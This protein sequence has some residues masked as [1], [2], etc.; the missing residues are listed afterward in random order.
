M[1]NHLDIWPDLEWLSATTRYDDG[2]ITLIAPN[3]EFRA[4]RGPLAQ[5]SQV[6]RNMFPL[7]LPPPHRLRSDMSPVCPIVHLTDSPADLRHFLRALVL[8]V[9]VQDPPASPT[10][11]AASAWIRL[12]HKYEVDKFVG[13]GLQYLRRFYPSTLSPDPAPPG[14]WAGPIKKGRPVD[15]TGQSAI[16]IVNLARLTGS[17]DLLPL[18]LECCT[19]G[20][21]ILKGYTRE[22]GT[23]E[24]MCADDLGLCFAAKGALELSVVGAYLRAFEHAPVDGSCDGGQSCGVAFRCSRYNF[25][26]LDCESVGVDDML[27]EERM[28]SDV[29]D[30]LCARCRCKVVRGINNLPGVFKLVVDEWGVKKLL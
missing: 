27:V 19:L 9:A 25:R 23:L 7:K 24:F 1:R 29:T 4:S 26:T 30:T 16:A 2:T 3:V 8:G 12:G 28:E 18:A 6:F 10:F 11:H 21:D 22:D 15:L 5:H 13:N 17:D 14:I 20:A